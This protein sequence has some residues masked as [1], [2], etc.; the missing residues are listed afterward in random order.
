MRAE[1]ASLFATCD[2][3]ALQEVS[4][5][6]A[7]H[8]HHTY[9]RGGARAFFYAHT[10]GK[11][12]NGVLCALGGAQQY[13]WDAGLPHR[14]TYHGHGAGRVLGEPLKSEY[15]HCT[16]HAEKCG[17]RV[18][19]TSFHTPGHGGQA[20]RRVR[21]AEIAHI[22][23][24]ITTALAR[25]SAR[26]CHVYLGDANYHMLSDGELAG[27]E[28]A[29]CVFPPDGPTTECVDGAKLPADVILATTKYLTVSGVRA[30]AS[31]HGSD[32]KWIVGDVGVMRA[33]YFRQPGFGRMT[34]W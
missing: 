21:S 15:R 7:L 11:V 24:S 34:P 29:R 25:P 5:D 16:I 4:R 8:L 31:A 19:F 30:S 28:D 10:P 27:L 2:I 9:N 13:D 20:T 17:V 33:V 23:A 22:A 12:A 26:V 6:T 3:V 32:H 18:Y 14:D 1:L